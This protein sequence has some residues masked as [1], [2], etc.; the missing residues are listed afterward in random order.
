MVKFYDP[1]EDYE[2]NVIENEFNLNAD[3][4]RMWFE[5]I[6]NVNEKRMINSIPINLNFLN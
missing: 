5:K 6:T 3:R 1:D 4:K 2:N